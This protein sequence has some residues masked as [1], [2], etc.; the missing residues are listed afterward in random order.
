MVNY[1]VE[2]EAMAAKTKSKWISVYEMA[3]DSGLGVNDIYLRMSDEHPDPIPHWS[4]PTRGGKLRRRVLRKEW[5]EWMASH[6]R[7][8]A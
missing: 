7:G 8:A 3:K 1:T 6:R 4:Y 5:E 2:E